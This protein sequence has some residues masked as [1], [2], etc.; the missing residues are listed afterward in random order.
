[1][2]AHKSMRWTAH[3]TAEVLSNWSDLKKGPVAAAT[4]QKKRPHFEKIGLV[5]FEPTAS[6]SRTRRDTKLRYSPKLLGIK[7]LQRFFD[8]LNF[9]IV[10]ALGYSTLPF[11]HSNNL[12]T[13]IKREHGLYRYNPRG[14]ISH[15][16]VSRASCIGAGWGLMTWS[17]RGE[18]CANL[19]TILGG[20][21]SRR[22]TRVSQKC[23]MTT[24]RR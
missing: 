17:M 15:G 14:S 22:A 11:M 13:R 18:N 7:E 5:G 8:A 12:W 23:W 9:S 21:M 16:C 2:A 19:R 1:M 20:P 10:T 24:R 6:W 3:G 4:A